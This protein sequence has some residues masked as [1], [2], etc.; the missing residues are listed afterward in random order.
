MADMEK[1]VL[2]SA[3]PPRD[4]AVP[5]PNPGTQL[6]AEILDALQEMAA[7][8]DSS[9]AE[10]QNT[11]PSFVDCFSPR[12]R[13]LSQAALS[14][15]LE[16]LASALY[17]LRAWYRPELGALVLLLLEQIARAPARLPKPASGADPALLVCRVL[18]GLVLVHTV[19]HSPGDVV[20]VVAMLLRRRRLP[21]LSMVRLEAALFPFEDNCPT[22]SFEE[23]PS[24][25]PP[26]PLN[27]AV[28]EEALTRMAADLR[29]DPEALKHLE[30]AKDLVARL[31]DHVFPGHR[32]E[33]FGSAV[34]GFATKAS[35][36]DCVIQLQPAV[37]AELLESVEDPSPESHGFK[38]GG[39]NGDGVLRR[40]KAVAVQ[41]AKSLEKALLTNPASQ[42]LGLVSKEVISDARVPLLKCVSSQG[43]SVD[44]SFNNLL[45]LYNSQLLLAYSKLDARVTSLGRLV[46]HWAR[47][48]CVN[49]VLEG[50]ISSYTYVLLLIHYL[51]RVGLV[52]NLQDKEALPT[53]E[54]G[55]CGHEELVDGVHDVW[56]WDPQRLDN[57]HPALEKWLD[58]A[59]DHATVEGLLIGFFRYLAYELPVYGEVVSICLPPDREGR[60]PKAEFFRLSVISTSNTTDAIDIQDGV[61]VID[62]DVPTKAMLPDKADFFA[63]GTDDAMVYDPAPCEDVAD[64]TFADSCPDDD[65]FADGGPDSVD[66]TADSVSHVGVKALSAPRDHKLPQLEHNVQCKIGNRLTL[67]V[68]DPMERG[69]T[70]GTTFKGMERL[71]YELRRACELLRDGCSEEALRS[72]FGGPGPPKSLQ[73]LLEHREFPSLGSL[74]RGGVVRVKVGKKEKMVLQHEQACHVIG[75]KGARVQKLRDMDGVSDVH[76]DFDKHNDQAELQISGTVAG[77]ERCLARVQELLAE[78][79]ARGGKGRRGRAGAVCGAGSGRWSDVHPGRGRAGAVRGTGSGRW[80]DVHPG[81]SWRPEVDGTAPR[82]TAMKGNVGLLRDDRDDGMAAADDDDVIEDDVGA[83]ATNRSWISGSRTAP[84][85]DRA[86]LDE[87]IVIGQDMGARPARRWAPPGSDSRTS[88]V[89]ATPWVSTW[90]EGDGS[91]WG[92]A[93]WYPRASRAGSRGGRTS[94]SAGRVRRAKW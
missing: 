30:D 25:P 53:E 34:N 6:V 58:N 22:G 90:C 18:E 19:A 4:L 45:P 50:T 2:T 48:R 46:K 63:E 36:L 33:Y 59:P 9:A 55:A 42:A 62:T 8:S 92:G 12:S 32:P 7:G 87:D 13:R 67:C 52:P 11:S 5:P 1:R 24:R 94:A 17:Q 64:D 83:Q 26:R 80:N 69:R 78:P 40:G 75:V 20:R 21:P 60:M 23:L 28:G 14:E 43:V 44:I 56:F 81:R 37:I 66:G 68:G 38:L 15:A 49:D 89:G 71:A 57:N 41:A 74:Q 31:V 82:V 54:W 3:P 93:S 16:G 70:L 88:P 91:A 79:A 76:L 39:E 85:G 73:R 77:V 72:L 86:A 84:L 65:T 35:D 10:G 27:S 47:A 51:Q 61:G 29:P